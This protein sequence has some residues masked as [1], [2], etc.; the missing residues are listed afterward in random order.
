VTHSK[1]LLTL[2]K[3]QADILTAAAGDPHTEVN[4][5]LA[6]SDSR[7]A[8]QS[9]DSIDWNGCTANSQLVK[10]ICIGHKVRNG[11]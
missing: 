2:M 6:Q 5:R 1:Y 11:R 9:S 3:R 8:Q 10:L 4:K 7:L